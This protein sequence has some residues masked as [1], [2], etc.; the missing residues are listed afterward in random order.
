MHGGRWRM[1]WVVGGLFLKD[2]K[3][4]MVGMGGV[5]GR[6]RRVLGRAAGVIGAGGEL[7]GAR[8]VGRNDR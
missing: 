2:G 5:W 3:G 7:A 1:R 8:W 4:G 6:I